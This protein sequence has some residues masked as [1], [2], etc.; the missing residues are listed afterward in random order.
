M[1]KRLQSGFNVIELMVVITLTG[2]VLGVGIPS[3]RQFMATQQVK[4]TAFDVAASLLQARSEAVKRMTPVTIERQ[5]DGW[6]SGWNVQVVDKDGN[7]TILAKR[8]ERLHSVT[9]TP[10]D[11][12][13]L[14]NIGYGTSGR[15]ITPVR[16]QIA[17]AN[18]DAVRCIT[19]GSSG[20]P[21][22][23]TKSCP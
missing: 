1:N 5:A 2:I 22:T 18:T 19:V 8:E 23:T 9:I 16:L 21:N 10:V 17:G 12:P 7:T 6:A 15:V 11:N 3:F 4:N 14:V 13:D 20:V